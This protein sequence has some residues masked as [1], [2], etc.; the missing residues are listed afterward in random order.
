[1]PEKPLISV[2]VPNYNHA[3]YLPYALDSYLSQTEHICE[4]IVLDDVSTDNSREVIADY[5]R[6]NP[7]IRMVCNETNLGCLRNIMKGVRL[8]RGEFVAIPG[9]DDFWIP[10]NMDALMRKVAEYPHLSFFCA[11][12]KFLVDETG[13]T[14]FGNATLPTGVYPAGS[15][16]MLHAFFPWGSSGIIIRKTL[17]E[18]LFP[19]VEPTSW[20]FDSVMNLVAALRY[21]FY[22]L[23]QPASCFRLTGVNFSTSSAKLRKR[24]DVYRHFF[25]LLRSR[26]PDLYEQMV[27]TSLFRSYDGVPFYLLCHPREWD[28]YTLRI[29]A[30]VTLP[31]IYSRLRHRLVPS[32]L[33]EGVRNAYRRLRRRV[34]RRL[35]LKYP[36]AEADGS[37]D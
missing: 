17:M 29:L 18:E 10:E 20:C 14:F 24:W 15:L 16:R 22:F 25:A 4:L 7:I 8:A 35:G 2:V 11:R 21:G 23:N 37:G 33:P 3:R 30:T 28:R 1:M 26:F 9:A 36:E 6:R 31:E 5:A 12:A 19:I 13:F 32:L 27:E 34:C